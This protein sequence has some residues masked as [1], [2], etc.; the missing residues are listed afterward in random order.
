[1]GRELLVGLCVIASGACGCES[2]DRSDAEEPRPPSRAPLDALG[3]RFARLSERL[4]DDY[5]RTHRFER[6]FA[7][8]EEGAALPLDLPAGVCTTIVALGGGGIR[9]LAITLYDGDG[10]EA[11]VDSVRAE[12]GL[13][14]VCPPAPGAAAAASPGEEPVPAPAEGSGQPPARRTAPYYLV[15]EARD[16]SGAVAAAA[17]RSRSEPGAGPGFE[18]LFEGVLAPR[19]PLG[20]VR[21]RLVQSR[22]A[23]RARGLTPLGE[24]HLERVAEGEVLRRPVQLDAERCY[25]VVVRGGTGLADVDLFLFDPGG[26]EVA[27]DL[28]SDA[29]P[30]L[31]HCPERAGRHIV[32]VRPFEGAGA[33][34]WML[35]SKRADTPP[36][37]PDAVDAGARSP[38]RRDDPVAVVTDLAGRLAGRGYESVF[39]IRDVSVTPGES[40]THDV[41]L[42][43]GCGVVLA[44]GVPGMDLDL[45]LTDGLGRSVDRD[46]RVEPAARAG[47]CPESPSLHRVVVKAYGRDGPY[48]LAVLRAPQAIEDV[49]SLRLD[50]ALA[51]FRARGYVERL[52]TRARLSEGEHIERPMTVPKGR[53]VVVAAAGAARIEDLDVFVR[54]G[55]GELVASASGPAPW[56]AVTR[57]AEDRALELQLE[58]LAYEGEGEAVIRELEA[59]R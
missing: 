6:R 7:L 22:T 41:L 53:C 18:D 8:E 35:L 59:P 10:N 3:R 34:G 15:I 37:R 13:V 19:V 57:C 16:G 11:A 55:E 49:Q 51:S 30:S 45:Y 56:G 20:R 48:A 5:E 46:T 58:V 21:K 9:D 42:G 54:D 40:R 47:A 28:E 39:V 33:L 52:T 27:R 12:G 32:E 4:S 24:P 44:A 26:T 29:E 17:F 38:P 1:M 2:P 50:E 14:H 23:L 25:V 36:Q 43:P 31:E